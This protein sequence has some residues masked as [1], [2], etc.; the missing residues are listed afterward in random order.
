[1]PAGEGIAISHDPLILLFESF[2]TSAECAT[3]LR[4]CANAEAA[5]DTDAAAMG[6]DDDQ[7]AAAEQL[8]LADIERRI[9]EITSCPPHAE[10]LPLLLLHKRPAASS[11]ARH[12]RLPAG[13]HVDPHGFPRRFASALLYLSSPAG[14]Q[15][16][17]PFAATKARSS[18]YSPQSEVHCQAARAAAQELIQSEVY[19]TQSS[20]TTSA[21]VVEAA[22]IGAPSVFEPTRPVE[23]A[24]RQLF[25]GL[26]RVFSPLSSAYVPS[27]AASEHGVAIRA[28]AGNL[29]V[30]WS[31][32]PGGISSN[33]W[34]GGEAVSQTSVEDKVRCRRKFTRAEQ[35]HVLRS[36]QKSVHF[37]SSH[38]VQ[39]LCACLLLWR[40][41]GYCASSRKCP[42]TSSMTARCMRRSLLAPLR[43]RRAKVECEACGGGLHIRPI[44]SQLCASHIH[45]IV[46]V[47]PAAG[48][49]HSQLHP[50]VRV[51]TL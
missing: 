29:L 3:L 1:M 51:W 14:G 19:H 43:G 47:R 6:V 28:K 38:I 42:S 50:A 39:R 24:H 23:T 32:E 4:I 21:R 40:G 2:V 30:F 11:T 5:S 46:R 20:S 44:N 8:L 15:T 37:P 34:H 41:S 25:R 36:Q 33:S 22:A 16:I 18:S 12:H 49:K 10:E 35:I 26:R 27:Y 31:R 13:L 7:F 17:F 48:P 9:G 45:A